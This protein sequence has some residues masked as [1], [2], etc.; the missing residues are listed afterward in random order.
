MRS[1]LAFA[2]FAQCH[3]ELVW[4]NDCRASLALDTDNCPDVDSCDND[5]LLTSEL[6][7]DDYQ[8]LE[9]HA[10][11]VALLD[12]YSLSSFDTNKLFARMDDTNTNPVTS[13]GL[14]KGIDG[15]RSGFWAVCP[16][17]GTFDVMSSITVQIDTSCYWSVSKPSQKGL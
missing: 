17:T 2:L 5:E 9:F 8:F 13:F 3:A 11:N 6:S 16:E 10:G 1:I 7:R 14:V 4:S 15:D 12:K